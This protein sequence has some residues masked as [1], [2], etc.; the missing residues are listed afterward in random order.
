M[1]NQRA[2]KSNFFSGGKFQTLDGNFTRAKQNRGTDS[3]SVSKARVRKQK[4]L[5]PFDID[6][7]S[8]DSYIL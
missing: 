5:S 2:L 4:V 8:E 7:S 3:Y 1:I 6:D